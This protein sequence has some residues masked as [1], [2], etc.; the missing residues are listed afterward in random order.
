MNN[1]NLQS[2]AFH[3]E[4]KFKELASEFKRK[5]DGLLSGI[6]ED[7]CVWLSDNN[8][9]IRKF[10][11]RIDGELGCWEH[12]R[13]FYFK[14]YLSGARVSM[15]D[16]CDLGIKLDDLEPWI[17]NKWVDVVNPDTVPNRDWKEPNVIKEAGK[18]EKKFKELAQEFKPEKEKLM[19][20]VA[21][22][23]CV[24]LS[25]N[26][27]YPRI[28]GTSPAYKRQDWWD[29]KDWKTRGKYFYE[30]VDNGARLSLDVFV[31]LG[32]DMNELGYRVIKFWPNKAC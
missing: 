26:G 2:N 32:I 20:V 21:E 12:S 1:S 30:H 4:N 3:L 14:H 19:D 23:I 29:V 13:C 10:S 9:Y 31:L 16:Y 7:L 28:E 24:W 22:D 11:T 27:R 8:L 15:P 5:R 17:K 6:A 25:D 18:L